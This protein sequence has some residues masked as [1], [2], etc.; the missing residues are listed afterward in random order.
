MTKTLVVTAFM[1]IGTENW[2]ITADIA[3]AGLKLQH[4]LRGGKAELDDGTVSAAFGGESVVQ[5]LGFAF[6]DA[7]PEDV[8]QVYEEAKSAD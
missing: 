7:L 4:W 5:R 6:K 2:H 1:Y 3:E 8:T